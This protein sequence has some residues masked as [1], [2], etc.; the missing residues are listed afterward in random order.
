MG[1]YLIFRTGYP[2]LYREQ[3]LRTDVCQNGCTQWRHGAIYQPAVSAMDYQT[4]LEPVCRHYQN[5][6]DGG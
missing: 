6:K 5:Q 4:F 1:P 3:H 2:L